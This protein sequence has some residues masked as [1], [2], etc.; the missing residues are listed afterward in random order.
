MSSLAFD[1]GS[2]VEIAEALVKV[3]AD[4]KPVYCGGQFWQYQDGA[5][6]SDDGG[7][8]DFAATVRRKVRL[9]DG[10]ALTSGGK[11]R[12]D[13]HT[14]D[15]IERVVRDILRN[16]RFFDGARAGLC[17]ANGFLTLEE[18]LIDHSPDH[19]AL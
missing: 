19:R 12:V 14:I 9:L 11:L 3:H 7:L 15:G 18:G 5:W 2:Q 10:A 4:P 13:A 17:V 8:K 1:R 6:R 16:D